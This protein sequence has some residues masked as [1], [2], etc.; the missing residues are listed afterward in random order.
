MRGSSD[1]VVSNLGG[2]RLAMCIYVHHDILG[3][4][5][6]MLD[7]RDHNKYVS[8]LVRMPMA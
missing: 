5:G 4:H 7:V 6:Q 3:L 2:P 1:V 8:F